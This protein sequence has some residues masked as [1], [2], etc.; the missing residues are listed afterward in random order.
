MCILGINLSIA[1]KGR[2]GGAKQISSPTIAAVVIGKMVIMPLIGIATVVML[3]NY[4]WYIP[5][6]KNQN[7]SRDI[8]VFAVSQFLVDTEIDGPFYLVM[9][10]VTITPTANN[11]MVMVELSGSGKNEEVA[12][13]I[14]WQYALAPLLLS[15]T[16]MIVV[17]LTSLW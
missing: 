11:V 14:A 4:A 3:K 16:V 13:I 9:M 2:D 8:Y 7:A 5:P 15:I 1:S 17:Q 10:I 6:G 12:R